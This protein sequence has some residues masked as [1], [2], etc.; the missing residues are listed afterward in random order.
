MPAGVLVD[1]YLVISQTAFFI[2]Q[3][4]MDQVFELLDAER[5]ELKN[6]RWRDKRTVDVKER[7]IGGCTDQAQVSAFDIG[8]QNVL[9]R[10]VEMMDLIDEQNRLLAGAPETVRCCGD[11]A[12]HFSDIALYTADSDKFGVCHL[13]YDVG[14]GCFSAAGGSG[15][16][17]R[18]QTIS[19]NRAAEKF[20]CSENVFL[21]D[22]FQERSWTHP[23]CE[24]RGGVRAR[25]IGIILV[26]KIMHETK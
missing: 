17:H 24:G 19:F 7:V 22:E 21:T 12:T 4:A 2:G 1:L 18:W 15:K 16:N 13:G 23:G 11:D 14:Q 10:F 20:P 5:L 9:L 26:E 6:L 8:K 25:N 3:S